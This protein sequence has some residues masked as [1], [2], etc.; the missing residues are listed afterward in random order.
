MVSCVAPKCLAGLVAHD[1]AEMS[2]TPP[3]EIE[4]P[5][6][7]TKTGYC[8]PRG[9]C[10]RQIDSGIDCEIWILDL[11]CGKVRVA[12]VQTLLLLDIS[13]PVILSRALSCAF[14][15]SI[16]KNMMASVQ[17]RE[18]VRRLVTVLLSAS[19]ES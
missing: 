18:P 16:A 5:D 14:G 17:A 13:S 12:R 6:M 11:N 8:L 10:L 7:G 15:S 19:C 9:R 4:T 1:D 3:E 2:T